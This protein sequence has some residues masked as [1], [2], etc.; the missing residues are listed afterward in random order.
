MTQREP[1]VAVLVSKGLGNT[2][3]ADRLRLSEWTVS[4]YLRRIFVKLGVRTRAAMV[5]RVMAELNA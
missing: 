1:Q 4:S 3:I 5:A 2:Q